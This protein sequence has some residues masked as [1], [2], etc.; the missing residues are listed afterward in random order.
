MKTTG[1]CLQWYHVCVAVLG[2]GRGN[3]EY[4]MGSLCGISNSLLEQ[5]YGLT[6]AVM[7]CAAQAEEVEK[8]GEG[9]S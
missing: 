9:S 3:E 4:P 6:A 5:C 1:L 7:P 2:N 8:V